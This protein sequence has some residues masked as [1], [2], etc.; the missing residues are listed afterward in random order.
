[1]RQVIFYH[2]V[3]GTP[4][5][6]KGTFTTADLKPGMQLA[7]M[8]VSPVTR[9]PYLLSVAASAVGPAKLAIK[10]VGS[11]ANVVRPNLK[12]G[13]GVAHGIDNLLLPVAV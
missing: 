12:C 6:G 13:A 7:T 3:T 1:M 4:G 9:Q 8:L 10:A 2:F 5:T 11:A